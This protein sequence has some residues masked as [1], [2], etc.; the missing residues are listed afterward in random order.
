MLAKYSVK[1]PFTVVVAVIMVLLLGAISFF[2]MSTDLLPS[3][4]LPYVV[5][6][7]S[8]PGASP[9]KVETAVTKPLEQ[10]LATTSGIVN[11]DSVSSENVSMLILEFNQNVNM[12]SAI[13]EM[14]G[15]IDLVKGYWPDGI[16]SPMLMRLN[17][18][19]LPV[20]AVSVDMNGKS[21][22]EL[23]KIANEEVIPAFERVEG[24]ASVSA[25]GL[26]EES[27]YVELSQAKIDAL[28]AKLLRSVNSKLAD[29]EQALTTA[30]TQLDSGKAQLA[31]QQAAQIKKL[32]EAQTQLA[33]G[34]SQIEGTLITLQTT[35]ISL[36]GVYS[37]AASQLAAIQAKIE[38][39]TATPQEI[40]SVPVL[41][42]TMENTA[43]QLAQLEGQKSQ[44][45]AANTELSQKQQLLEEGKMTASIEFAKAA[46][47][48]SAAENTLNEKE[49]EFET[50]RDEALKKANLNGVLTQSM[51]SQL[52]TAQNFSMP[53]GYVTEGEQQY[54]V[55][56]GEKYTSK[57][58]LENAV[59]IDTGTDAIGAVRLK[60]VADVSN[61]TNAGAVYAKI[62]GND[63]IILTVQKQSTSSTVEVSDALNDLMDTLSAKTEGLHLTGL[64]DQG[65]YIHMVISSVLENLLYG[66]ILA[67]LILLVFLRDAR[68]TF[69]IAC[70][71]PISLLF[72]M[73]MM[74]FTNL[75]LN[76]ISLAGL[77]LGIGMLVDNSIV[78]IENIYRLRSQ[79][80]GPV[81]AAIQGANQVA[82]A[83]FA[84]TMTTVCVFL[85]IVF[86]Q[87][88]SRQLFTDM[89]LTIAYSLIASLIVALTLV[90]MMASTLLRN[91][92]EKEHRWFNKMVSGYEK[93]LRW[94]LGHRAVILTAVIGLLAFCVWRTA[95]MGTAFLPDMD[96]PQMT[97]QLTMPDGTKQ[98]EIAQLT[99]EVVDRI[100]QVEGVETIGALQGGSGGQTSMGISA[101]GG[102]DS[103]SMYILLAEKR[104]ATNKEIAS[105]IENKT[106]DLPCEVEVSASTMDISALGGS[107]IQIKVKG[108]DLDTLRSIA[109][110]VAQKTA[111][112]PGTAN[113]SN[114]LEETSAETRITV[115]KAKAM[116]NGLT[117][118]Q[119][120]QRVSEAL[121]GGKTA[122]TL[123]VGEKEYPVIVYSPTYNTLTRDTLK[124]ITFTVTKNGEEVQVPLSDFATLDEAEGL[125]SI[126]R[127]NQV[128]YITVS[129]EIA[130]GY[131][132]GLVSRDLEEAFAD[133]Q[134]PD[135][136][137]LEFSGENETINSALGDLVKM[138]ALAIVF[139]Y[140]IMVAQFQSLLSPFIV[141]FT[142][143][144]AFT[145]GLLGLLLANSTLSVISMLGFLVLAGV[146][147]N[148]GIVFVDYVNQLR[149]QGMPKREALI[150]T[151]KARIRPILMTAITTI[152]GL[153][154][155]AL[156]VGAGSDMLQPMGIVTVGGLSY[157]TLLT[158]FVVP[159][160]YDLFQRKEMKPIEE[161]AE[162]EI[163]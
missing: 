42:A 142:L 40:A 126:D 3:L 53:A 155:L 52:L 90:P 64:M 152:L 109:A 32:A 93:A 96:S 80:V 82:G 97:V 123:T 116:E 68:P 153:L 128:R 49:T 24:V 100:S 50:A 38:A 144:L 114:G 137:Q 19:M 33:A 135:G 121:A 36:Q 136:Y 151:G 95:L 134:M 120:Y 88:I 84:S 61:H 138:I 77:A 119:V 7:T 9:E 54:L 129:S 107:G 5:V 133:Y 59:L 103:I 110:D 78:V 159:I 99:D 46:G 130:S 12:D 83:I 15:S 1:K 18:D 106:A 60:D 70:S 72:A 132:I 56:V 154:T 81:R 143:P 51:L 147:V 62:N 156:G 27:V 149:L 39:G 148:N 41:Q 63:G 104:A 160:L 14:N 158:L 55:K 69:I 76:V 140:L 141:M 139:I 89:G 48:L 102:K 163:V 105:E 117:V 73:A 31:E 87:G 20:M 118:A 21:Q 17:P 10:A 74:Y 92:P 125:A 162:D 22:E 161:E 111:R 25:T 11:I 112:V 23:T 71:I 44:L 28:N 58:E 26:L 145:G 65:I 124:N 37:T 108:S 86:T 66:G 101:Q 8:Y 2:N 91:T 127:E 16:G 47:Q 122:T 115:D 4:S 45:D 43:A 57:E 6:Y 157:A 79:G 98:E 85:P 94:A 13:I 67:V 75:T 113:V 150:E 34:K 29:G 30:R 131:N 35:Q 146:V